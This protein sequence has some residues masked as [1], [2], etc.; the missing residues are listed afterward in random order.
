MSGMQAVSVLGVFD[1]LF[2]VCVIDELVGGMG[3]IR[4]QFGV[5]GSGVVEFTVEVVGCEV[6]GSDAVLGMLV[7][8]SLCVVHCFNRT[9]T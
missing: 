3:M 7:S 4:G 5:E 8:C 9:S 6:G 2:Q 1:L